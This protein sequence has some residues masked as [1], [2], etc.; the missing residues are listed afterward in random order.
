MLVDPDLHEILNGPRGMLKG[1]DACIRVQ[2]LVSAVA[3]IYST[4]DALS[5]LTR[6]A[7]QQDTTRKEFIAWVQKYIHPEKTLSCS[8]RDLYG[9]RCGVLHNY[10]SDSKLRREGN[11]K[12][13]IYKWKGGPDP[14]PSR[15]VP[16]PADA[17]TLHVEDLRQALGDAVK[18]F[19]G[20]MEGSNME[21]LNTVQ[22]H[23][24]EL[25]CYRP[26]SAVTIRV[27][28]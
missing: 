18:E 7:K 27:A 6:P 22:N 12:A 1:V 4:I 2:C 20:E 15:K 17:I 14:D 28:A 24:S 25:L 9:A 26:W 8:A 3:L 16:L 11:A 10:G 23:S 13:L 19:F 21:L 5:A